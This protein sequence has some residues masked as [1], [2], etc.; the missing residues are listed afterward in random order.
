V[1]FTYYAL[2]EGIY[3][4]DGA[5]AFYGYRDPGGKWL[6]KIELKLVR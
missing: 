5:Y 4:P 6:V 1:T 2:P 3:E